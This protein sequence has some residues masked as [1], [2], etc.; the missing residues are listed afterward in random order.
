MTCDM[1]SLW[2]VHLLASRQILSVK[3]YEII[4]GNDCNTNGNISRNDNLIIENNNYFLR[5]KQSTSIDR[6]SSATFV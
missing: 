1:F 3:S 5:R 6:T 4:I 2:S